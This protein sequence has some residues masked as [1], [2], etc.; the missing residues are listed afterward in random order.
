MTTMNKA[1]D[2]SDRLWNTLNSYKGL[3][4][5]GI[6]FA[7][8]T[9]AEN[10]LNIING[11]KLWLR[12]AA[13]MNDVSEIEH[14]RACLDYMLQDQN[15]ARFRAAVDSAHGGLWA[16]IDALYRI[17]LDLL[18]RRVF[19]TSLCEHDVSDDQGKLSMWRAY[20]S[21]AG[22]AALVF[23][24]ALIARPVP[25]AAVHSSKVIYAD[26][27]QF[28]IRYRAVIERLESETDL[29]RSVDR[30]VALEIIHRSLVFA[31]LSCKH[32]GFAEEREWRLIYFPFLSTNHAPIEEETVSIA[33]IPQL[34]YKAPL[35]QDA[36]GH[37]HTF[38]RLLKR[39]VVGPTLYPDIV[40]EGLIAR[41]ATKGLSDP[42]RRVVQSGIPLRQWS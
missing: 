41:L 7:H 13:V 26:P 30:S 8:Y 1:G 19:I 39:V 20:G 40:A 21:K 24:P 16:E 6:Q 25:S 29:I 42:R 35:H 32:M 9:S 37:G 27:V 11:E 14:G 5:G 33:G 31:L 38:D 23:D 12:A 22:G 10:A 2:S 18:P 34:I 36:D 28:N 4:L 15:G 17:R 3:H